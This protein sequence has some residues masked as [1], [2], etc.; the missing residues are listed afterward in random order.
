[1]LPVIVEAALRSTVLTL[2]V[3]L[4]LKALRLSNPHIQM[5]AWRTVLAASLLMPFFAGWAKLPLAPAGLT[6]PEV[7]LSD[8]AIFFGPPSG[9]AAAA[10]E[11]AALGLARDTG[12]DLSSG[13]RGA[14]ASA[15]G[16]QC[17]DMEVMPL[18]CA[19][20]RGVDPGVRRARK[21]FCHHAADLRVHDPRA[22]ELHRLGR[23]DAPGGHGA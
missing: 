13:R 19:G 21:R 3:L 9:T 5:T 22:C 8:A 18:G 2:V 12:V 6:I 11:S 4:A 15:A 23:D 1:M 10:E 14:A 16:R 20:L 17:A 7:F